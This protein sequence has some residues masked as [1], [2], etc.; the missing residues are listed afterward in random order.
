V[1]KS[2]RAFLHSALL[3]SVV[4]NIVKLALISQN[5]CDTVSESTTEVMH[6]HSNPTLFISDA[7]L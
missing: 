3:F 5:L 4:K 6:D 7:S 2:P 1:Y